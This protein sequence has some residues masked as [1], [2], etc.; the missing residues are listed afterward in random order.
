MLDSV[1]YARDR[2]LAEDGL[3]ESNAHVSAFLLSHSDIRGIWEVIGQTYKLYSLLMGHREP[4]PH[5]G[6]LFSRSIKQTSFI[7]IGGFHTD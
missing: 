3:G 1:L 4:I 6:V 7:L 5:S 2:Y